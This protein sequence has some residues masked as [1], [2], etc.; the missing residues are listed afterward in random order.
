MDARFTTFSRILA[1]LRAACEEVTEAH[2]L[3]RHELQAMKELESDHKAASDRRNYGLST[4]AVR[5]ETETD[6]ADSVRKAEFERRSQ[7]VRAFET[8]HKEATDRRLA[9][10]GQ[11]SF[12]LAVFRETDWMFVESYLTS[13][14]ARVPESRESQI[15]SL[16]NYPGIVEGLLEGLLAR[17]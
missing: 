16:Q 1:E 7:R 15:A 10:V 11:L 12:E 8:R 3:L 13:K 14:G 17:R 2:S 6:E 9:V 4:S 5:S